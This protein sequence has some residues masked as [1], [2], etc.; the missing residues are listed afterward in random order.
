[1]SL[2]RTKRDLRG[3]SVLG[4]ADS[5]QWGW[6][7]S[8]YQDLP[9]EAAS[10]VQRQ[11]PLPVSHRAIIAKI[12]D[13]LVASD[14]RTASQLHFAEPPK[15]QGWSKL[16]AGT[17]QD[18]EVLVFV[19]GA[20]VGAM[21]GPVQRW[22]Y[23]TDPPKADKPVSDQEMLADVLRELFHSAKDEM[24]EDGMTSRFSDALRG[25]VR[26]HD[27]EAI[28]QIGMAIR[29]ADTS[30]KV[31]EEALRQVGYMNDGKTH[32]AR[33]S[34]LERSLESPDIRIR[35]A[36]SI[37]IEA[38]EDPAAIPALKRAIENEPAGWLQQYLKDVMNQLKTR[39]EVPEES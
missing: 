8:G 28:G 39:Y 22:N 31:A 17:M 5:L 1:M 12:A 3:I 26:E 34:L 20:M 33:L 23:G 18:S 38:M 15:G 9:D 14:H 19:V 4:D 29:A 25:I 16:H 6:L 32:S 37:G 24:F 35:D 27:V 30:V 7:R 2:L 36:A 10:A 13:A 21:T 11:K